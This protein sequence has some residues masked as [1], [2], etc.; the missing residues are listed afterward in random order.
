MSGISPFLGDTLGETYCAV[1]RG[2]W[3]FDEEAFEGISDAAKDFI[4]KLL[5]I[6]QT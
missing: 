4:A 1:E 6:D 3:E 2:Q 5:I